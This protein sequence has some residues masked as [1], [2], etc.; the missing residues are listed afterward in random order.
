MSFFSTAPA[1]LNTRQF[2][3]SIDAKIKFSPP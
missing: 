3:R 1:A 2:L